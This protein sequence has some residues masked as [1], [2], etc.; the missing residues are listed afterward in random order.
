M[1][2]LDG[3]LE[4]VEAPRLGHLDLGHEPLHNVLVHDACEKG[5]TKERII[6][7]MFIKK[8]EEEDVQ[9]LVGSESG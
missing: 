1:D 3:D 8:L 7:Q 2:V 9:N 6:V 5:Q 4:A